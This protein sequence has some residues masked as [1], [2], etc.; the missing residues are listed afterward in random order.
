MFAGS[1]CLAVSVLKSYEKKSLSQYVD[2]FPIIL[3]FGGNTL[4]FSSSVQVEKIY[5]DARKA[6]ATTLLILFVQSPKD[7]R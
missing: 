2:F 1:C 7:F 6:V 3:D 4:T 5:L